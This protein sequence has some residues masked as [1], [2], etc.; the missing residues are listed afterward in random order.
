MSHSTPNSRRDFLRK[1]A[2][3]TALSAVG[4]T[5]L[6]GDTYA[7]HRTVEAPKTIPPSDRIRI[8]TIGMGIIGFIDTDTALMVPG[9]ELVAAADTYASRR[10][11]V[12]E[13]YGRQVD[14][15]TDYRELLARDDIDAVLICTPDHLHAPMSIDAMRAKKAVYCEKPMTRSVEEGPEVIKV[16]AETKAVFQVGSQ[17]ASSILYEKARDLIAAG[18]IGVLNTVEARMNRNSSIGAW[19]YSIPLDATP[20]TV[21]WDRFLGNAPKRPFDK[22]RYFR[23]RNYWDYGTA[24]AGDLYV[25]LFTGIHLATGA[26]G[27]NRVVAMG[28]QRYW[29]DGRDVYDVIMGLFD[30]PKTDAHPGFTVS[31]QTNFADGGG[32]GEYFR[33]VGSEGTITAGWT[34][35]VLS[36]VGI[37]DADEHSADE[38]LR[39][40]N[41][42]VTWSK[43][44]QAAFAEDWQKNRPSPAFKPPLGGEQ[45]FV[46]PSGYDSRY[47]HFVTFFNAVRGGAPVLENATFGHRAAA[48]ALLCNDSYRTNKVLTWDPVN[49]KTGS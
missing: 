21:D 45:R 26:L 44:T 11:H 7:L 32:G 49:L 16:A 22:T 9:V 15:Y 12:Q 46:V 24:V 37:V 42:V 1:V 10:V 47:D 30:Y 3:T 48:P 6:G 14:V 23:W 19:Q 33:F 38:V 34:D 28:G 43:E 40:Y 18:E 2:A 20:E 17:Y 25:H 8:A 5:F 36:K 27:P 13:V 31:L 4:T 35:L 29:N 39:G 41:S